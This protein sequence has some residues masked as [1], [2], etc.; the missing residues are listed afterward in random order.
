MRT[1]ARIHNTII[2]KAPI[3]TKPFG[4]AEGERTAIAHVPDGRFECGSLAAPDELAEGSPDMKIARYE[5]RFMSVDG[6]LRSSDGL[7]ADIWK[8]DGAGAELFVLR[9]ASQHGAAGH[10]P[11]ILTE[12]Y[13]PWEERH[14]YGPWEF[15]ALLLD[16]GYRF[17]FLCRGGLIEHFP[18]ESTPFPPEFVHGCNVVAYVPGRHAERIAFL[19]RLRSGTGQPMRV[20]G[21]R[22]PN[23]PSQARLLRQGSRDD[24]PGGRSLL[25]LASCNGH[26]RYRFASCRRL[27]VRQQS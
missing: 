15:F 11:L 12:V 4:L 25:A 2:I 26:H 16:C 20:R 8:T 6:F 1:C 7:V 23:R 21:G 17:L 13:A 5:R 18:L 14:G 22:Y 19:D 9:G 24:Q 27:R 10:R 3:F